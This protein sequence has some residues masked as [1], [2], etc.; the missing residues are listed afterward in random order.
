MVSDEEYEAALELELWCQRRLE[1]GKG[2]TDMFTLEENIEYTTLLMNYEK[3]SQT[4]VGMTSDHYGETPTSL[5][6]K[7]IGRLISLLTKNILN[8]YCV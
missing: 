1:E 7:R 5:R 8:K 4:L 6:V 3:K 2:S